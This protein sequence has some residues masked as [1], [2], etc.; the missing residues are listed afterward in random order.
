V[1]GDCST[2][3]IPVQYRAGPRCVPVPAPGPRL[4]VVAALG[5]GI[6]FSRE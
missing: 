3:A 6:R 4:P 2:D 1:T 5:P